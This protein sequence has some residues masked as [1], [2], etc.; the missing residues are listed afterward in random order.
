MQNGF[1]DI[2]RTKGFVSVIRGFFYFGNLLIVI[3]FGMRRIIKD[4][5]V[6]QIYIQPV[7]DG[8]QT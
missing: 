6:G 3:I 5:F 7:K 4:G 2:E 1:L 8:G